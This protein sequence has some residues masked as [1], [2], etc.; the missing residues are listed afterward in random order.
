[1]ISIEE[2]FIGL[3]Q[4][5]DIALIHVSF[6]R[7]VPLGDAAHQD[8]GICLKKDDQIGFEYLLGQSG[9][10]ALIHLPLIPG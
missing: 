8:M 1:M 6:K 4:R 3:P 2:L 7:P 10:N 9:M 5:F